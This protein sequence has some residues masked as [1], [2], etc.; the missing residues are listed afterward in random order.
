MNEYLSDDAID[1]LVML[2][3]AAFFL[4]IFWILETAWRNDKRWLLPVFILPVIILLFIYKHWEETRAKCFFAAL[5]IVIII[6]LSAATGYNFMY[7]IG[8]IFERI[9][10]WPYYA[11][12]QL[13]IYVM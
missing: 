2:A 9:G 4:I 11:F 12:E 10:F 5:Y 6:L 1:N 3:I 8:L 7:R 13:K